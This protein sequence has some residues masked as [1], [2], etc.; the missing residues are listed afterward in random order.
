MKELIIREDAIEAVENCKGTD[1]F[2]RYDKQN[3][4][5]D[6]AVEALKALPSA[7]AVSRED[8]H[9]LLTALNDIDRAL[10]QYQAKDENSSTDDNWMEKVFQEKLGI[11]TA[12][13]IFSS[14]EELG[15]WIERMLWHVDRID[16]DNW[17]PVSERL[18]SEYGEYLA[19]VDK[20]T[21]EVTYVPETKGLVKGW[22]TCDAY[23]Y[24]G[25]SDDDVIAW[26]P[27]PTPYKKSEV[28]EWQNFE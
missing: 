22:S 23:G 7:E 2:G 16:D 17:I 20:E 26:R 11:E 5:I 27:K 14:E 15:N 24:K 9:N 3:I 8:Y 21:I 1:R 10:R 13:E 12:N 4:G 28:E 25:L 18:P 19:T 6:W